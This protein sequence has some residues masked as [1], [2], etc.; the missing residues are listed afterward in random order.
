MSPIFEF[1]KMEIICQNAKI[2]F[3]EIPN[4]LKSINLS[5]ALSIA[6]TGDR[7]HSKNHFLKSMDLKAD[8]FLKT[9][10]DNENTIKKYKTADI[11]N[12]NNFY[13]GMNLII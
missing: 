9:Q 1:K 4:W 10:S 11:K 5:L 6:Q 12:K 8:I 2:Q 13:V 3:V 7:Q